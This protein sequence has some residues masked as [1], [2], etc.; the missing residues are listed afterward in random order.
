MG[1]KP[2]TVLEKPNTVLEKPN[3]VLEA[4]TNEIPMICEKSTCIGKKFS[5]NNVD[6]WLCLWMYGCVGGGGHAR[7]CS[8]VDRILTELDKFS[9]VTLV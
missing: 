9:L 3:T 2:N 4:L 8:S 6:V 5:I 7:E 1:Y